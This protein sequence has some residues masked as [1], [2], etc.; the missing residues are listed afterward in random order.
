M[1]KTQRLPNAKPS[2]TRPSIAEPLKVGPLTRLVH[3]LRDGSGFDALLLGAALLYLLIMSG[4]PMLYNLIMSFQQVDVFSL[5]TFWRPF[6]GWDN[7]RHIISQPDFWPIMSNT[8]I[9]VVASIVFQFGIGFALAIFFNLKFTGATYLRGLFLVAWVMPGLVV[10]AV[11]NWVLAGDLGVLNYALKSIG[12][13][14][15][16]IFWTSDTNFALWSVIMANVWLGV[17]FNM[18]LLSVGL[19]NIPKDVY[20]AA[21]LDGAHVWQRFFTI[22]L[23]LMRATIGA[24]ISLGVI[25][26]LQQFDLV[27]AITSG[28]PANSSNVAQ[29]WAWDLSFNQFDFARGATISAIMLIVV[30]VVSIIYIRSTRHEQQV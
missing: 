28:G 24:V 25:L 4:L 13:I 2:G 18:I 8:A 22:T 26:T 3:T 9:F 29:Y 7:F 1:S 27:A 6:V 20:E 17:P 14:G 21:A 10:G 19:A 30:M 15:S 16:N 5:G 12:L 23:P 11:W